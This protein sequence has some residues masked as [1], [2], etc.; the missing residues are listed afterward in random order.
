MVRIDSELDSALLGKTLK[1][2]VYVLDEP[3]HTV[4]NV[5]CAKIGD[6]GEYEYEKN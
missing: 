3:S 4:N 6:N 2:V 1:M 5:V